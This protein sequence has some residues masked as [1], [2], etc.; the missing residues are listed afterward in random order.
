MPKPAQHSL[1][2]L[3]RAAEP[4][5]LAL[6]LAGSGAAAYDWVPET[7]ELTWSG[8]VEAVFGP[9]NKPPAARMG[10][11]S[12]LAP[13]SAESFTALQPVQG[14]DR[15][16]FEVEIVLPGGQTRR[17][18]NRGMI[19][20]GSSGEVERM[21]G[22]IRPCAALQAEPAARAPSRDR[23]TGY[24]TRAGLREEIDLR[25]VRHGTREHAFFLFGVDGLPA[26]NEA[27]GFDTADDLIAAAARRLAE[28]IGPDSA[29]GRVGGN[30]LGI[31]IPD[32]PGQ[33]AASVAERLRD[34]VGASMLMTRT[35][36]VAATVSCGA[37]ALPDGA[38]NSEA[39]ILHAEDAL[40]RARK[41][42]RN[43]FALYDS[44]PARE[45]LRRAKA[46]T[47]DRIL[48]AMRENRMT[49]AYQP[50]VC[51][52][53]GRVESYEA[54]VRMLDENGVPVPAGQF[55]PVAEEL[56]LVREL[57]RRVLELA[58]E[59]LK[60]SPAL[61]LSVNASGMTVGDAAWEHVFQTRIA[62][63][64]SVVARLTVEVTETVAL[65][66]IAGGVSFVKMLRAA[67]A[68]VAI[69]D[70][71]AGYTSFRNLQTLDINSVK[72]DGTFVK[73]I[74]ARPDNQAFVRTLVSLAKTFSLQ[75]VAEWVGTKEE[76]TLLRAFGVDLLQG[77]AFGMPELTPPWRR[78]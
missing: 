78:G 63:D 49:L 71:G 18:E 30:K 27:Y 12:L 62:P 10:L 14:P 39:A 46:E 66:D 69:D 35:G 45:A 72:I 23:L 47:G 59:A 26:I 15:Y 65:L 11:R 41:S 36:P 56:G 54:L 8:D 9:D 70:F 74:V 68:R 28:A 73:G 44:S 51:A 3:V 20:R 48:A 37:V 31:L 52:R 24:L 6:A 76:A 55:I 75:T 17:L 58:A 7:D 40:S 16:D 77:A 61:R 32:C 21:C 13:G 38:A 25:L 1:E 53:T 22:V 50:I 43:T 64:R 34:E 67:G 29:I 60:R 5:W 42:G 33:A 19:L 4:S 57:D 2:R